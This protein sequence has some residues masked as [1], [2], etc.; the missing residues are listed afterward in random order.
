MRYEPL[1]AYLAS[2]SDPVVVMTYDEIEKLLGRKLP[3]TAYGDSWR[4]WWANTET[5]SQA[6]AW[7][8]AGWRVTRPDLGN[9]RV[10]FRR[11]LDKPISGNGASGEILRTA[12]SSSDAAT[13]AGIIVSR[14][15]LTPSALR[16][17]EDAAEESSGD[18]GLAVA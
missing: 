3:P 15:H 10:E 13:P 11:Q 16:M 2:V 18:L 12:A 17:V 14:D 4:Q 9:Q 5:H 1:R 7:L 6:L 8:R